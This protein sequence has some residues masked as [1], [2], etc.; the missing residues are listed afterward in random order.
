[1]L[2]PLVLDSFGLSLPTRADCGL[3]AYGDASR[4]VVTSSSLRIV[5]IK[6]L[7]ELRCFST[8]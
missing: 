5:S 1:M 2:F 3:S 4:D 7:H 8:Y 6:R